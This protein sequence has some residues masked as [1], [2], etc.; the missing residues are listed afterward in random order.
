MPCP[1]ESLYKEYSI[2]LVY[3]ELGVFFMLINM[4]QAS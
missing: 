1:Y 3:L 2:Y 4:Y